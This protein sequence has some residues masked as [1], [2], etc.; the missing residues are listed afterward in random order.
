MQLVSAVKGVMSAKQQKEEVGGNKTDTLCD[1]AN[2]FEKIPSK[3]KEK[4]KKMQKT[5]LRSNVNKAS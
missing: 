3:R 2:A 1:G 4:H 5:T